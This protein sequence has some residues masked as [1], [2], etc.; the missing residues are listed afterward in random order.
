MYFVTLLLPK[1]QKSFFFVKGP[2]KCTNICLV[3]RHSQY[4]NSIKTNH[5]Y[6]LSNP[7]MIHILIHE[8]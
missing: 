4:K 1:R 3:R 6:M 7:P 5:T 2:E 8:E